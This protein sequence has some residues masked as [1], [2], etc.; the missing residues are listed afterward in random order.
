MQGYGYLMMTVNAKQL[1]IE[2][3]E[4]TGGVKRSFDAVT[5]DVA[6]HGVQ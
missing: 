6:N 3:F 2:M 1:V 4:T 5:V